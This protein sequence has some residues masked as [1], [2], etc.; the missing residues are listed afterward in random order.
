MNQNKR[1]ALS[2]NILTAPLRA[3]FLFVIRSTPYRKFAFKTAMA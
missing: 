2:H 3:P 1:D